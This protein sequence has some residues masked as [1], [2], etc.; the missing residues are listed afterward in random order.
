MSN[1]DSVV[2]H[3]SRMFAY[4]DTMKKTRMSVRNITE[5]K[6]GKSNR[7]VVRSSSHYWIGSEHPSSFIDVDVACQ[8]RNVR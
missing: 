6:E 5:D 8:A 7:T 3:R 2:P 4:D 1:H